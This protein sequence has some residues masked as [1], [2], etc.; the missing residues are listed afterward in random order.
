MSGNTPNKILIVDDDKFLLNM[1]SIKFQKEKFEV[2]VAS[3]GSE[4]LKKLQEGLVPDAIVLDIVMPVMDGLEFLEKMREGELAKNAT[5]LILSNQG[6]SSD[7]DKAKRLGIDGYIV[8][9]TTIPS[10]VVTEVQRMLA[11]KK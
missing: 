7:I 2:S 10:E 3:D 8:K 9:A 1:Y 5:V 11:N 4:A 6:Q